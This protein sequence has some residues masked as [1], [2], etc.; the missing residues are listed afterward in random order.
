MKRTHRWLVV[1]L[2]LLLAL[3][4]APAALA[5]ENTLLGAMPLLGNLPGNPWA[6]AADLY[7]VAYP[8]GNIEVTIR[9]RSL[10]PDAVTNEAFGFNLY[11]PYGSA[12]NAPWAGKGTY[13]EL[14][15]RSADPAM[16][17]VQVYNYARKTI[18]YEIAVLGLVAD[19]AAPG[20][21]AVAPA[22]PE[23]DTVEA[24]QLDAGLT[25]YNKALLGDSA[26]RFAEYRFTAVAGEELTITLDHQPVDP[27]F[28]RVVSFRVYDLNGKL[29]GK[30][31]E[32]RPHHWWDILVA[33]YTGE[34]VL[35][36]HNYAPG[37]TLSYT[38][39]IDN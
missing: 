5:E 1:G 36:V 6:G 7:Q 39:T 18:P 19:D 15:Y 9:V 16:L 31:T 30:G 37:L 4:L 22:P 24:G 28:G 29:V 35:Q 10:L 33:P 38:L 2:A 8:G 27:S 25:I 12:L 23:P 20:L 13:R 34:Y 14:I 26:G 3:T 11:R 17:T 21:T 32:M